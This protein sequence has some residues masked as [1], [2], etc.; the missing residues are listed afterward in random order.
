[1]VLLQWY[2]TENPCVSQTP[3]HKLWSIFHVSLQEN[4]DTLVHS[5]MHQTVSSAQRGGG[6]K[7]ELSK[8]FKSNKKKVG[9]QRRKGELQFMS[10]GPTYK[11]REY[12]WRAGHRGMVRRGGKKWTNEWFDMFPERG[13]CLR[14]FPNTF[15][16]LGCPCARFTRFLFL[17]M[18]CK[19]DLG[20]YLFTGEE[21]ETMYR[22][23]CSLLDPNPLLRKML[24]LLEFCRSS[25]DLIYD[26]LECLLHLCKFS[27][28]D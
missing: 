3:V 21:P 10:C 20:L 18:Q 24:K 28:L 8:Q 11:H 15:L 9:F 7:R 13:L 25:T 1:M 6:K 26:L 4:N 5:D 19:L 23:G 2:L 14:G 27:L 17:N 12:V 16:H 22:L